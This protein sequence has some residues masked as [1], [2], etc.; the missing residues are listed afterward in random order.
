MKDEFMINTI[1][2]GNSYLYISQLPSLAVPLELLNRGLSS[3]GSKVVVIELVQGS[4]TSIGPKGFCS[5]EPKTVEA[6][7]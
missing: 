7:L 6:V 5:S 1:P 4:S 2:I 3:N